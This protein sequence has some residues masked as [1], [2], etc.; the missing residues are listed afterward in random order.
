MRS[1][2]IRAAIVAAIVPLGASCAHDHFPASPAPSALTERQADTLARRDHNV[3][4]STPAFMQRTGRGYIV[5]YHD[6][7]A[8]DG[9][10]PGPTRLVE[11]RSS[12]KVREYEFR[13][14]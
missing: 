8:A 2:L 11:V 14:D 7:F 5:A 3:T 13:K 10:P 1:T 9:P 4:G 12:G 6:D